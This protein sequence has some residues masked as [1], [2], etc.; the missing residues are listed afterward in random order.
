MLATVADQVGREAGELRRP[1]LL[2]SKPHSHHDAACVDGF[3]VF[4]NQA[5]SGGRIL[6]LCHLPRIDIGNGLLRKP[7]RILQEPFERKLVLRRERGLTGEGVE[8]ESLFG[9]GK[10][11]GAPRRTQLH[12][13]GHV[14][15]PERHRPAEDARG[16]LGGAQMRRR[17]KPIGAGAD[18]GHFAVIAESGS[19][20][21]K[22][23]LRLQRRSPP[24]PSRSRVRGGPAC[25]AARASDYKYGRRMNFS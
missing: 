11:R 13:P 10:V 7:V 24:A 14:L 20:H 23:P 21:V 16:H 22:L 2:P 8:R 4:E 6:D 17:R 3:S 15:A 12:A 5:E 18:H 25:V 1:E 9:I 19:G